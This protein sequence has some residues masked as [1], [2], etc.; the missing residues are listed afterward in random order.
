MRVNGTVVAGATAGR[1]T[2]RAYS[3]DEWPGVSMLSIDSEFATSGSGG[4]VLVATK[5]PGAA[6]IAVSGTATVASFAS[7]PPT[8]AGCGALV[9]VT[10]TA[11]SFADVGKPSDMA[12]KSL[13]A[14][15][16]DDDAAVPLLRA[17]AGSFAWGQTASSF[18]CIPAGD[19]SFV[20]STAGGEVVQPPSPFPFNHPFKTEK[21]RFFFICT[22]KWSINASAH[23]QTRTRVRTRAC[24]CVCACV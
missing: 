17:A 23:M 4:S 22:F 1:F 9:V 19:Y 12:W 21:A 2:L 15:D 5:D 3:Q 8:A 6:P 13:P 16:A 20:A 14:A 18:A 11:T 7:A 10:A 24:V